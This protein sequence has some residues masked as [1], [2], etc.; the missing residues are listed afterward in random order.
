MLLAILVFRHASMLV[1]IIGR[2][3]V[4]LVLVGVNALCTCWLGHRRRISQMVG[5]KTECRPFE[6]F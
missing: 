3:L 4:R 6:H 5:V 2:F 1:A